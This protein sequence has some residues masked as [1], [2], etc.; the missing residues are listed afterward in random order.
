MWDE[1]PS[2][3]EM[4]DLDQVKT[5]LLDLMK[6]ETIHFS[7]VHEIE[8]KIDQKYKMDP[9][10]LDPKL[11]HVRLCLYLEDADWK[12]RELHTLRIQAKM[13]RLLERDEQLRKK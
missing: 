7:A 1:G 3:D 6:Q 2:P 8:Q 5:A 11:L 4:S 10:D 13:L 9:N 12:Q